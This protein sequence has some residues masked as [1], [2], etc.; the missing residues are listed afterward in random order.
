MIATLSQR[1]RLAGLAAFLT[2]AVVL[3]FFPPDRYGF[4]PRCPFHEWTGLQCPGCGAT[5]AIAAL[6][7]AHFAEAWR[8]NAL[9]VTLLPLLVGYAALAF[10]RRQWPQ[11]PNASLAL[12]LLLTAA[13]GII[14]N[15]A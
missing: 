5:R 10:W 15:L 4:Y 1:R 13:F 6:L 2:A 12:A 3:Y 8:L 7:H 9:A 11:L 14:R